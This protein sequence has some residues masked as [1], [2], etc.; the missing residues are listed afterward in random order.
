MKWFELVFSDQRSQRY[1][2]HV[3]FWI[4]WWVY[5]SGSYF[6]TQQ[7]FAQAGSAKWVLI[8]LI[9]SLLLLLCHLFI[10]YVSICLLLPRFIKKEKWI[11]FIGILFTS[12][13]ITIAWG[14][15]C[16]AVLFPLLENLFQLPGTVTKKIL[17]WNSISAGLISSLK[18]VIAAV[19]IK[20]LKHWWFKQKENERLE[21]EKIVVELQLL[22]AQIQPEVLFSSLEHIHRFAQE[23]PPKASAML[24]KLSDLLSY[25]LYECDQ[26]EVALQKELKMINNYLALQKTATNDKL[27]ISM[28]VKGNSEDKMIAPLVLLPF[29]ENSLEYCN[30]HQLEKKWVSVDIKIGNDE[31]IMKLVNGKSVE[32]SI[33]ATPFQNGLGQINKRLQLLYPDQNEIRIHTEPEVMMTYLKIIL[34]PVNSKVHFEPSNTETKK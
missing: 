7:G 5:F 22:K 16:Y 3:I 14:Y 25:V 19:A 12:I 8:I 21:K 34:N 6:F 32:Q 31:L 1:K 4:T 15:F 10:V 26:S 27:E 20:L 23:N 17:L 13:A 2:R 33:P 9:K 11:S 24:L 28:T 18:V 29:L 30:Q